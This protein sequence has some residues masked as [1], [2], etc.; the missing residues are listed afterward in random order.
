MARSRARVGR[1][2]GHVGDPVQ[3][4]AGACRRQELDRPPGPGRYRGGSSTAS[5]AP[6]TPYRPSIAATSPLCTRAHGVGLQVVPRVADRA[7][8]RLD[9]DHRAVRAD[10]LGQHAREQARA[11][12]QVQ[13]DVAG[14]R[15][16]RAEPRPPRERSPRPDAPAR[17]WPRSS[18]RTARRHCAAG[19][20]RAAS[21]AR[22]RE[23]ESAS[24]ATLTG[25]T[26]QARRPLGHHHFHRPDAGPALP[27]HAD[28]IDQ[29]DARSGSA[30]PG[31]PVRPVLAQPRGAVRRTANLTRVRQPRPSSSPSTGS[32]R[33]RR[34]R[35]R[36][37]GAAAGGSP[38][39]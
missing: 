31:R 2:A 24:T 22:R 14:R 35:C 1:V 37:S 10:R 13:H 9:A 28:V 12:V 6:E 30:G 33:P 38:R 8:V 39:P 18:A 17:T 34:G 16:Q 4:A 29:I 7:G 36:R 32:T 11:A 5:E 23:T 26:G 15:A 21:A 19:T 27:G 20:L 25:T 3:R